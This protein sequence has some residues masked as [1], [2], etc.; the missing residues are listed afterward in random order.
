MSG[1]LPEDDLSLSYEEDTEMLPGHD[2]PGSASWVAQEGS[3]DIP[4]TSMYGSDDEDYDG[5]FQD[6]VS[7]EGQPS[8]TAVPETEQRDEEM[9]DG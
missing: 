8:S 9:M 4:T 3:N 7:Q 5:L 6:Y 1:I 2:Q